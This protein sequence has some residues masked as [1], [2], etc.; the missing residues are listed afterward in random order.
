MLISEKDELYTFYELS[1]VRNLLIADDGKSEN[2]EILSSKLEIL[3][4]KLNPNQK[5][6]AIFFMPEQTFNVFSML[7]GIN[8]DVEI[9]EKDLE[10]MI[11]VVLKSE[12]SSLKNHILKKLKV[13]LEFIENGNK[14]FPF[15][16]PTDNLKEVNY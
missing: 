6:M 7:Q 12:E 16:T 10:K 2:Y 1:Y 5:N 15:P 3:Q 14:V 13:L 4:K 9:T 8:C 11:S